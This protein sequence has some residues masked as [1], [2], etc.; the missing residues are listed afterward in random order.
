MAEAHYRYD[1]PGKCASCGEKIEWWSPPD[2]NRRAFDPM[3]TPSSPGAVPH[4]CE[5]TLTGWLNCR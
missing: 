4:K 2:A 5:R 1:G 3:L